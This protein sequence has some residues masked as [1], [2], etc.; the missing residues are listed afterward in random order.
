VKKDPTDSHR[1]IHWAVRMNHKNRSINFAFVAV[2][3]GLHM[4]GQQHGL[5]GWALLALQFAIYPQLVYA[6]ARRSSQPFQAEMRNMLFDALCFGAW[7]GGLLFPLWITF[8]LFIACAVNLTLF[9]GARGLKLGAALF[10]IGAL[11]A[12]AGQGFAIQPHT[13]PWVTGLAIALISGFLILI[14]LENHRRSM[15]LHASKQTL[16]NNEAAL[17]QQLQE[18]R[19]LHA[20]VHNQ[21]IHDALTGLYNRWYLGEVIDRELA[22]CTRESQKMSFLLIDIDHFKQVNDTHGHHTGDDVL[23]QTA[24]ILAGRTR[25]SDFLFRYGGEEFLLLLQGAD[26]GTAQTIA[27]ALR[28]TYARTTL[29]SGSHTLYKTLSIGHST[30]PD[31]GVTSDALL[32]AADQALYQAKRNGRNQVQ[33]ARTSGVSA[34]ATP[35]APSEAV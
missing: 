30:F 29:V 18:I 32:Q 19:D 1:P 4:A 16:R 26:T 11:A 2:V 7:S 20:E 9:G 34:P 24:A 28:V 12:G 22:R 3:L 6:M 15:L 23:G 13:G 14:A 25:S 35:A 8:I 27:E 5:V 17:K 21:A 33:A 10:V 31:D